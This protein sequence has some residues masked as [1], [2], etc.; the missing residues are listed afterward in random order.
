MADRICRRCRKPLVGTNPVCQPCKT[1][2]AFYS[3]EQSRQ[4]M[5]SQWRRALDGRRGM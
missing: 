5:R 1:R 2:L 3:G 4:A